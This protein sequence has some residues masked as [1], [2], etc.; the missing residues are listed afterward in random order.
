M[1][2]GAGACGRSA[3][4]TNRGIKSDVLGDAS[5]VASLVLENVAVDTVGGGFLS[6]LAGPALVH[7]ASGILV[8]LGVE[9]V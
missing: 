7:E 1:V 5:G 4:G 6:V 3:R 9:H 2:G 8:L